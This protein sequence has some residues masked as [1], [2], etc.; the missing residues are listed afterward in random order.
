MTENRRSSN[1][2]P[3]AA[4]STLSVGHLH[5]DLRMRQLTRGELTFALTPMQCRLLHTFMLHPG[6]ILSRQ[7]LMREVWDTDYT[8]DTRTLEVHVRWIRKKIEL[9]PSRPQHLRTVR[10]VGYRFDCENENK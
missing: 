8:G 5:L 4:D 6:E 3:P 10:G 7:F 1:R 9:N 2:I